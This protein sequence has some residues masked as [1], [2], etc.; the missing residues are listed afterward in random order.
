MSTFQLKEL[1]D[2]K[3]IIGV[4]SDN[5]KEKFL[6]DK[7][8]QKYIILYKMIDDKIEYITSNVKTENECDYEYEDF[9]VSPFQ[10]VNAGAICLNLN[11][12]DDL[13]KLKHTDYFSSYESFLPNQRYAYL[14]YLENPFS[15]PN[16][17][18]FVWML[19]YQLKEQ[20]SSYP[21]ELFDILIRIRNNT[22]SLSL[23]KDIFN[24]IAVYSTNNN[25]SKLA[26]DLLDNTKDGYSN[27]TFIL[28]HKSFDFCFSVESLMKVA[29][30]YSNY[31]RQHKEFFV[32]ALKK[33]VDENYPNGLYFKDLISEESIA[34]ATITRTTRS[35][36]ESK[37]IM[38]ERNPANDL[39][40][41]FK[42]VATY[43]K[44]LK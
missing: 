37:K 38:W 36:K 3:K 28:L 26:K 39:T 21:N 27:W 44:N 34:A 17:V 23:Q 22:E 2:D 16:D 15:N 5:G 9:I 4:I 33:Y 41:F 14:K 18:G 40:D 8:I 29:I 32:T 10:E 7:E 19:Y 12:S 1:N 43:A 24:F 11:V 6:F 35:G 13:S 20:F 42:K 25:D 30:K 31:A